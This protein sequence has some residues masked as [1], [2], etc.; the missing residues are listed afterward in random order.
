M[1]AEE[2]TEKK[3]EK[4]GFQKWYLFERCLFLGREEHA[5]FSFGLEP[6]NVCYIYTPTVFTFIFLSLYL[7]IL[8]STFSI[9]LV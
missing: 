3:T 7:F 8:F 5:K 9:G 2:K 1:E 4:K 6:W